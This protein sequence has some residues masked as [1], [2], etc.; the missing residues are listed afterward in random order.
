M[1]I[2]A[3]SFYI[4]VKTQEL[5]CSI[6]TKSFDERLEISA[7]EMNYSEIIEIALKSEFATSR[8]LVDN[9]CN[10]CSDFERKPSL[11]PVWA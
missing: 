9:F 4:K 3:L 11:K 7:R 2:E 8:Y 5:A 10:H 6:L 1:E